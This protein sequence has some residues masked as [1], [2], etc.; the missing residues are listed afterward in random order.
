MFETETDVLEWYERQPRALSREFIDSIEWKE[1]KNYE[2]NPAFIPVLV[3]MRDVE[4]FTELYYKELLRTPTGRDPVI[5]K[6]MDRWNTEEAEHGEV[7]NRFLAEAGMPSSEHWAAEAKRDIPSSYT[8]LSRFY[9]HITNCFGKYFSGTH[10]AWGAI[11]EM[12]TLQGYRRLW[13]LAEHPVLEKL[14]RAIAQEESLHSNFY[15]QIARLKLQRSGFAQ[16]L[17]NFMIEKF[18]AP[19]GTGPKR[20]ED[21]KYVI[22]TLFSGADGLEHFERN[23]NQRAQRLPGLENVRRLRAKVEAAVK[24]QPPILENQGV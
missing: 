4:S 13:T 19:V 11:N 7:L 3:Y 15:W 14:L 6:F 20:E 9:P 21:A 5:R 18:W 1:V 24:A 2:L 8:F 22:S 17:A 10:M 23:V 16:R 12:T